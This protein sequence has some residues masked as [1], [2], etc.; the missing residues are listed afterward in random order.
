M[1]EFTDW[2]ELQI[3]MALSIVRWTFWRG[4]I[5]DN[6]EYS[7]HFNFQLT[8]IIYAS[9]QLDHA[10][11][12]PGEKL[13]RINKLLSLPMSDHGQLVDIISIAMIDEILNQQSIG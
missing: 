6:F 2:R 9:K 8:Y 13:D 10:L 11:L 12:V 5:Y 7:G 4:Y 3:L 1:R